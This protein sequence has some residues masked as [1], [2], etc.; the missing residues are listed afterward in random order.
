[1]IRNPAAFFAAWRDAFGKLSEGEAGGINALLAEMES[2]GWSDPRWWAYVLATAYHETGGLMEPIKETVLASHRDRN[3]ADATVIARLNKAWA[4]GQLS[5]VKTPYWKDGWFGRGFVQTTHR[6]NYERLGKAIGVD[7]ISN[8]DRALEPAVAAAVCCEGMQAGLFTGKSLSDYFGPNA[9]DPRGA[10]RIVNGTDR[11]D[12]IAGYYA[13][14]LRA[15]QAGWGAPEAPP[16][17][18]PDEDLAARVAALE[19][20]QVAI[21]AWAASFSLAV[22]KR[23]TS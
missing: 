21:E 14:I 4:S 7:L 23:T 12:M 20:R 3:P 16:A 17:A 6:D 18:T 22:A 11:A 19:E 2:R 10:R 13:T 1:M 5:W 8:R 15:V 9:D